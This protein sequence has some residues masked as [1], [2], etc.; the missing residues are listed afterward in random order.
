MLRLAIRLAEHSH[1]GQVDKSGMPYIEHPKRVMAM[2]KTEEEQIVAILHDIVEDTDITLD[3]I[4]TMFGK[5]ISD[6]VDAIT[7]RPHEP[8]EV[9]YR[10]VMSNRI[11]HQVKLYDI[12]DN[13]SPER[14]AKLDHAT[15]ERLIKKYLTAW[16]AL[17]D[18]V[19]G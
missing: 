11:A 8:N 15:Q 9:Y 10:R 3:Y 5:D 16:T 7:H 18:G 6:A 19:H 1:E 13:T 2:A 4:E 12:T 14:L 17:S